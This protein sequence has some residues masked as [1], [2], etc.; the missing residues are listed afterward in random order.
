MSHR[1]TVA[2]PYQN[3]FRVKQWPAPEPTPRDAIE[4]VYRSG[5]PPI[6]DRKIKPTNWLAQYTQNYLERDVISQRV[7]SGV[8]NARAKGKRTGRPPLAASDFPRKFWDHLPLYT[9]KKISLT[10][11]A[12]IVGCSRPTLYR[13]LETQKPLCDEKGQAPVA[14]AKAPGG[15]G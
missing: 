9:E 10:G 11:F 6:Y 3:V 7:K 15:K 4:Q 8:A 14:A 2:L 12:K 1:Q 5:S 13:Y